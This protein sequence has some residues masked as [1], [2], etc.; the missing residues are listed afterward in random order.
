MENIQGIIEDEEQISYFF[1][2]R[3][4][5][6]ELDDHASMF[7]GRVIHGEVLYEGSMKLYTEISTRDDSRYS[8]AILITKGYASEMVFTQRVISGRD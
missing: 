8:D 6:K 1:Y 4:Q 2:S 7:G 5:Q 3:Q